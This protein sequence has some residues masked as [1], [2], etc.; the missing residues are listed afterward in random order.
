M[1]Y[2]LCM[3][4]DIERASGMEN[5]TNSP[6]PTIRAKVIQV[7][8]PSCMHRPCPLRNGKLKGRFCGSFSSQSYTLHASCTQPVLLCVNAPLT[9]LQSLVAFRRLQL[10]VTDEQWIA[11]GELSPLN[12]A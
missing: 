8:V 4:S 5:Y 9:A 10:V 7:R 6:D 2:A 3:V 11:L 12:R 1:F